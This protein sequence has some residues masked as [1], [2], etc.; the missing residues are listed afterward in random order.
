MNKV[1]FK[2]CHLTFRLFVTLTAADKAKRSFAAAGNVAEQN[3]IK[4]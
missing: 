2:I 4:A 3:S 1:K